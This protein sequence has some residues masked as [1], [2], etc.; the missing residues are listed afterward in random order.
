MTRAPDMSEGGPRHRAVH[1]P[2]PGAVPGRSPGTPSVPAEVFR[3]LGTGCA[4]WARAFSTRP[5]FLALAAFLFAGDLK[6]NP[7]LAWIPV[8]LTLL[9]GALL[10][11][12][13]GARFR[14]GARLPSRVGAALL[15]LWFLSFAPG[16][17]LAAASP[18]GI[19]K[20][21]TLYTFTLLSAA[22][23]MLLLDQDRDAVAILN[24][25]ACFCLAITLGG[26][27]GGAQVARPAQRLQA[28]GA[29]TISLGRATG[30]LFTYA[31]LALAGPAPWPG[32]TFG[33]MAL[34]GVAALFSGS[35]GPILAALAVV[36]LVLVAGRAGMARRLPRLAGAAALFLLL[37]AASLSLAP[38]G[39]LRRVEAFFQGQ[40]GASEQ[41]RMNALE[42]CW[43]RVGD[44]PWGIGWAGFASQ[45]DPERGVPRQYPHNLLA[46]VTLEAGWWCG[47]VT[48]LVLGAAACAGWSVS[49]RPG[50]Q[51]VWAGTLF[52]LINAMVSGDVN[53]NR[54]MFM[55]IGC[56]LTLPALPFR[57]GRPEAAP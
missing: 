55:F 11:A 46:E 42:A 18:Y 44:A 24:A 1:A 28:F 56:A 22:A 15:G 57:P 38:K 17:P 33:I 29:G 10:C 13:L 12:V 20:I 16:L 27:L 14:R 34:A 7:R 47:G 36:A 2:S 54:P 37:L 51:L 50:G 21:A 52:Y 30:L 8:D 35:R 31:A 40:Y 5:R 6:A 48:L 9:T 53:D 39:S 49:A 19:Q 41:Y 3:Y 23:P 45:V 43:D 32:L 26:L 4:A 25:M